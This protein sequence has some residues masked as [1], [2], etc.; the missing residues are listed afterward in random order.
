ME[1]LFSSIPS[2][3]ITDKMSLNYS[4]K[5]P[6]PNQ[7]KHYV[8]VRNATVNYKASSLFLCINTDSQREGTEKITFNYFTLVAF[9]FLFLIYCLLHIYDALHKREV[10]KRHSWK[11]D[12]NDNAERQKKIINQLYFQ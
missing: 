5:K 3:S 9:L 10:V 4:S 8:L 1:P 12:K 7:A 6:L 11:T 2:I